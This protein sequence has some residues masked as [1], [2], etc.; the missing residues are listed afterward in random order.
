ML[1]SLP[2][3]LDTDT[4]QQ[5]TT[6]TLGLAR[7]YNLAADDA[8]YLELVIRE[9]LLLATIALRLDLAARRCGVFLELP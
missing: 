9:G 6:A 4:D 5:S 1:Q 7:Q 3:S 2:I 8:G